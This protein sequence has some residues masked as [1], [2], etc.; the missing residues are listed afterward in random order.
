DF[1]SLHVPLRDDTRHLIGEAELRRMKPGAILVNTA[2][3]AVVDQAALTRALREGWI[4][5]AGLDVMAVEPIPLGDPLLSAPNC[6]LLPHIGSATT[7]TRAAMI[8]LAVDNMLAPLAGQ[9]MPAGGN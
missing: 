6:V 9:P 7:R 1:V 2:R 8:G 5:G 4:G 3:G